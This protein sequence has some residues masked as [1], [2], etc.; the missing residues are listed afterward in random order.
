MTVTDRDV[1]DVLR[2]LQEVLRCKKNVAAEIILMLNAE[3]CITIRSLEKLLMGE[4]AEVEAYA[5]LIKMAGEDPTHLQNLVQ[6]V[7]QGAKEG[8]IP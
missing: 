7:I 6:H 4:V 2:D 8:E 5:Y 1:L 3:S